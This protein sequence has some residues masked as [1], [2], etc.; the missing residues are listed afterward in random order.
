MKRV[1]MLTLFLVKS[2]QQAC[3]RISCLELSH[4]TIKLIRHMRRRMLQVAT[5]ISIRKRHID[6][7]LLLEHFLARLSSGP[8]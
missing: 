5:F 8:A 7:S 1:R 3:C 6:S 4:C 2:Q